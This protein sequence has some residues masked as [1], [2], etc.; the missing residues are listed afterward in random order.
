MVTESR[1]NWKTDSSLPRFAQGAK[2]VFLTLRY[3]RLCGKPWRFYR[4]GIQ[5]SSLIPAKAG[6]QAKRVLFDWIPAFAG[7]T[8]GL[9]YYPPPK[10]QKDILNDTPP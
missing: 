1:K 10:K 4:T 2:F 9:N 3:L 6:I 7:M 8:I 5:L